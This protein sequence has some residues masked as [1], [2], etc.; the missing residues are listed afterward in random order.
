MAQ[1]RGDEKKNSTDTKASGSSIVAVGGN[2]DSKSIGVIEAD[3]FSMAWDQENRGNDIFCL[4]KNG[5]VINTV[6][7]GQLEHGVILAALCTKVEIDNETFDVDGDVVSSFTGAT[8]SRKEKTHEVVKRVILGK[9]VKNKADVRAVYSGL[10]SDE[11]VQFFE[12]LMFSSQK[13]NSK[14]F[15]IVSDMLEKLLVCRFESWLDKKFNGFT[16]NTQ[17]RE[18][19]MSDVE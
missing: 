3:S 19:D 16:F 8:I 15:D 11:I 12:F 1:I 4:K 5:K 2:K 9:Q 13:G 6:N 14:E 10:T 18:S 7:V 17:Q